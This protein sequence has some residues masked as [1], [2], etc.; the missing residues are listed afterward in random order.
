MKTRA[1]VLLGALLMLTG[2]GTTRS[3]TG[4]SSCGYAYALTDGT[5][6]IPTASCA[7]VIPSRP[8]RVSLQRGRRFSIRVTSE[9]GGRL[10]FPVP[11]PVGSA[12]RLVDRGGSTVDYVAQSVGHSLLRSRHTLYCEHA[13]PPR[14]RSCTVFVITVTP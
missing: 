13:G 3:L 6:T 14:K 9:Q 10:A 11:A 8:R 12:V 1:G 5:T 2:C 7:G 4:A